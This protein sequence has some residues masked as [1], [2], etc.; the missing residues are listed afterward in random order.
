M[1]EFGMKQVES[2][3]SN[4]AKQ[5][6]SE[7]DGS[8]ITHLSRLVG[9]FHSEGPSP[10]IP[11]KRYIASDCLDHF[12]AGKPSRKYLYKLLIDHQN[13]TETWHHTRYSDY[14]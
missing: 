3:L 8:P 4:Q 5:E 6:A 14:K 13:N 12:I 1:A 10:E 9:L 2:A 11:D 7:T